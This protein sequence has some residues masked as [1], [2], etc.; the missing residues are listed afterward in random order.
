M[1]HSRGC[2]ALF[3]FAVCLAA[4]G[5]LRWGNANEELVPKAKASA[6]DTDVVPDDARWL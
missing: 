3:A 5:G 1:T 2:A 4:P 6:L